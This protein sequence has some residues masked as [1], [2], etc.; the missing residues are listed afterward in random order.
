MA[1]TAKRRKL[2]RADGGRHGGADL[3]VERRVDDRAVLE[4]H[5][6]RGIH[7]GQRVLAP[8]LRERLHLLALE[9]LGVVELVHT[10]LEVLA[11]MRTSALLAMCTSERAD[12]GK[13][14]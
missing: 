13:K 5:L 11:G 8:V 1:L 14:K 4:R 2:I 3:L 6:A 10:L 9:R 12:C 7:G